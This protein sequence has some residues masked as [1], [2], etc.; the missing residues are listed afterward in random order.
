MGTGVTHSLPCD[1]SQ[2]PSP[3]VSAYIWRRQTILLNDKM[4]IERVQ[5]PPWEAA[6]LSGSE[7]P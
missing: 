4:L 1:P 6:W 2:A 5:M 3:F 7:Q